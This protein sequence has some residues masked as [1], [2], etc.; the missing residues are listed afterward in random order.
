MAESQEQAI[1]TACLDEFEL[2]LLVV[3]TMSDF[4][5]H[6][7][8]VHVAGCAHCRGELAA[9]SA[10]L[11]AS[12]IA[13]ETRALI[14]QSA[15]VEASASLITKDPTRRT[16]WAATSILTA[17]ATVLIAVSISKQKQRDTVRELRDATI[18]ASAA[19]LPL[20]P[21]GDVTVAKALQ[22][23]AV[24][25]AN[26]YRVTLYNSIA[27]VLFE[28]QITDT[29][30]VLPDSVVLHADSSYLWKVEVRTGYDRWTSSDLVEFRVGSKPNVLLNSTS[31]SGDGASSTNPL[32]PL[33]IRALRLTDAQLASAIR[34]DAHEVRDA[35]ATS[36]AL[37]VNGLNTNRAV[38]ISTAKRIAAAYST[39]W[40]DDYLVHH[41][42]RF[43]S[44]P[45]N[46][47]SLKLAADSVRRAGVS[48]LASEGVARAIALWKNAV[49]RASAIG[50]TAG[51]AGSLGNIGA[52][53]IESARADSAELYLNRSRT[54]AHTIGDI[55][56]EANALSSLA[57]LSEQ[58]ADPGK[59]RDLYARAIALR[60]G[61]GDT[62]GL[63]SDYNNLGGM[64]RTLGDFDQARRQLE[65]ALAMNRKNN[66]PEFAATNLI[67]LAALASLTGDLAHAE[68]NYREALN[69]WRAK[70]QWANVA[71]AL[72]GMGNLELRR[73][74]YSA[75]RT[76]LSEALAL[77]QRVN[78][79]T[80]ALDVQQILAST[81]AAMGNL[82]GA[83]DEL[84]RAQRIADSTNAPA[85]VRGSIML[86]RGDLA[87][88]QNTF[89]E[90]ERY[91][92]T[93]EKFFTTANNRSG[94][95]EA[96]HGRG[97][98]YLNQDNTDRAQTL[99]T[100]ALRT[101][102][103]DNNQRAA[104]IT[105]LSLATV[106]LRQQDTIR[107]RRLL[108]A[109]TNDFKRLGD[110]V[111]TAVALAERASLEFSAGFPAA[112]DSLFRE[113]LTAVG[114]RAAPTVTWRLHAGLGQI[115]SE[116]GS[117]NDALREL[118]A[119]VRDIEAAGGSYRNVE[120]RSGF[121]TDKWNV[122]SQLALVE[123]TRGDVG[124]AFEVS[125][126]VRAA[127]MLEQLQ[128]GRIE[129][130]QDMAAPLVVR[131][132][133]LRHRIA[134][135]TRELAE[136]EGDGAKVRGANAARIGAVSRE[137]LVR[138]QSEYTQLLV[139][140]HDRAPR[141]TALVTRNASNW[142]DVT[143]RLAP[144]EAMIEYL[145]SD[146]HSVAFV[147]TRDTLVE[148]E[149]AAN[150]HDLAKLVD[151]VRGTL[152]PRASS[153]LDSLWRAPLKQLHRDLIAPIEATGLL[154]R[155]TRLILIPQGELHYLPFAALISSS[156]REH[157]LV[158]QYLLST[159]PSASVWL[160]LN[161]RPKNTP[162][163]GVLAF[164]PRDDV[165][166]GTRQEV[167]AIA[168]IT[169]GDTRVVVGSS[170]TEEEFRKLAPT[171]RVI[172]LATNG[173]LNKQNPLFSFVEFAGNKDDDGHLEAR[174]V[175]G[176]R[177]SAELVVLSACQTAL[178]SGALTDIP[179]GDD[180]IGLVRAFLSAGASRVMA[181]LW[182]VQDKATAQLMESFYKQYAA[183][184]DPTVALAVAQ[185]QM[186]AQPAT[187]S[188]YFWAGFEVVGGR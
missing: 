24:P 94:E 56:V 50:D 28:S 49:T 76:T 123:R 10:L 144:D 88:R 47:R 51:M 143:R 183:R 146:T 35:I 65:F 168:R 70:G 177:L 106:A 98:M 11:G 44:W 58:H 57:A 125:E 163:A 93:A 19:P 185:R 86:A 37:S 118:R 187:A 172:H 166:P 2:S 160:T 46:K 33:R 7:A 104:A 97:T 100:T 20:S 75:A 120:R 34:A 173:V 61:I 101:Q 137:A 60:Q 55:R 31:K 103:I 111:A 109:T 43:E 95:A 169:G 8:L 108:I 184:A 66:Q 45:A 9:L 133:D 4:E 18:T 102:K 92:A 78:A 152:Q 22:W 141:H 158:E 180:W 155:K 188:P 178:A 59:A 181:T 139:D 165:L 157:F 85:G 79:T 136:Q 26:Q 39:A 148:V 179:A 182:P 134:E 127:E 145:L 156:G 63:A 23:S 12:T 21:V 38:E 174:E 27:T 6:Q 36:L 164:A 159:T 121:L 130:S 131:E 171:R 80:S 176:L 135:L 41:I 132:Q 87:A 30:I 114:N 124:A 1:T 29:A 149:L 113:G 99:F 154:S 140:V 52:G 83:L 73:G 89:A 77:Y 71:D 161:A 138:A 122:Y 14:P 25:G 15:A 186:L 167:D 82:Q 170:A 91:Y 105:Q 67:N 42:A 90:A 17:A 126:R 147:L 68:S 96:M 62:R 150:R 72:R 48:A 53:F 153:R 64:T 81:L 117:A 119:A 162:S 112:A 107:A 40:N 69:T 110:P 84:S 13:D 151:F 142:R 175:F 16:W 32:D 116:R 5:R 115:R 129:E 54:L 74:N 3:G 128:N